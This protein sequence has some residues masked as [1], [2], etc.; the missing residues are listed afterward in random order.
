MII[1]TPMYAIA[2]GLPVRFIEEDDTIKSE[3]LNLTDGVW[4]DDFDYVYNIL[5]GREGDEPTELF[6][7]DLIR[8]ARRTFED[9]VVS[10]MKKR[11]KKLGVPYDETTKKHR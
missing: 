3:Y 1:A 10:I 9:R 8:M 5:M 7:G 2:D 4:V 6:K 11:A